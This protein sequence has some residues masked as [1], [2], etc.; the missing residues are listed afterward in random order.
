MTALVPAG[1]PPTPGSRTP[2][3]DPSSGAAP[4]RDR[5]LDD[6]ALPRGGD[7]GFVGFAAF[8]ALQLRESFARRF[9]GPDERARRGCPK[10]RRRWSPGPS[11]LTQFDDRGR[12][13]VEI[14][15]EEALGRR[16]DDRQR[17]SG[18]EVRVFEIHDGSDAVVAADELLLG[19]DGEALE[20]LGNALLKTPGLELS[21]PRLQFRRAPDRLWSSDPVQFRTG[22]FRR[23][24]RLPAVPD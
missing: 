21:G 17:F 6:P 4:F 15:A 9:G 13:L 18:V 2:E 14:T 1:S 11:S 24:R 7:A 22:R 16:T 12:P 19:T 5:P 23:N 3:P 10:N 20:F 8:L